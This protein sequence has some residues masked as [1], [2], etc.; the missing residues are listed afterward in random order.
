MD[1]KTINILI[2]KINFLESHNKNYTQKQYY[3]ILDIQEMLQ[4]EY[5]QIILKNGNYQK[6]DNITNLYIFDNLYNI[7]DK[8]Y[9]KL[10]KKAK[11]LFYKYYNVSFENNACFI[12]S[13]ALHGFYFP[14]LENIVC[15]SFINEKPI[16]LY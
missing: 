1:L 15:I 9:N 5:K 6:F 11:T 2:E 14:N 12:S 13:S 16:I 8:L 4:T 10:Y 3:N 7:S